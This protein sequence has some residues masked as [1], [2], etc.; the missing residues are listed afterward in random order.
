MPRDWTKFWIIKR[1][2]MFFL[3]IHYCSKFVFV[4]IVVNIFSLSIY[5]LDFSNIF[6]FHSLSVPV[7]V[8]ALLCV[9]STTCDDAPCSPCSL[10][11]YLAVYL[12]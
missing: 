8:A 5:I 1:A 7:G 3:Y 12:C 11:C 4:R 2:Y 10:S 9:T 6:H